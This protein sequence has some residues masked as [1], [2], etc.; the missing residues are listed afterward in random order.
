[1]R[2][3]DLLYKLLIVLK[4]LAFMGT[5]YLVIHM[6]VVRLVSKPESQIV[7]FF[8]IITGPLTTPVRRRLPAGT[9]EVRVLSLTLGLLTVIWLVLTVVAG[10]VR[11][12]AG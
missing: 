3:A 11:P 9:P 8:A 5:M 10:T 12:V 2:M 7:A 4:F 1:M 6:L